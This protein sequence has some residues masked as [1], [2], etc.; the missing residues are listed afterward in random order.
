MLLLITIVFNLFSLFCF[1][2]FFSA[3]RLFLLP[4]NIFYYSETIFFAVRHFL[5]RETFY[6]TMRLLVIHW[7]F[8]LFSETFSF[9]GRLILLQWDFLLH[10]ETFS[11]AVRRSVTVRHFLLQWYVFFPV[12]NFT[13]CENFWTTIK[14]GFGRLYSL[15]LVLWARH[16]YSLEKEKVRRTKRVL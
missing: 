11:F 9:S 13:Q 8:Y 5:C 4:W 7:N 12:R 16:F 1:E 2:T 3:V 15:C 6:F 10:R 14:E